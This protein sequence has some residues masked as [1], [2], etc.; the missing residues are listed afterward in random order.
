M[1]RMHLMPTTFN[2]LIYHSKSIV[3]SKQSAKNRQPNWTKASNKMTSH[4]SKM[5]LQDWKELS[6]KRN[7]NNLDNLK[8]E[9]TPKAPK[10]SWSIKSNN[11]SNT[12][13]LQ[14]KEHLSSFGLG[15]YLGYDLV[16]G[17]FLGQPKFPQEISARRQKLLFYEF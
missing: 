4:K 11:W 15:N 16:L 10:T 1:L 2:K 13:W 12:K 17:Q 14:K 7:T 8:P 6:Q 5:F 9:G 3:K